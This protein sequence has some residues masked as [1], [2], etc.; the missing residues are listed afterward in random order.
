MAR[1][2]LMAS[3]APPYWVCRAVGCNPD[4]SIF[5]WLLA[6]CA[7]NFSL[8]VLLLRRFVGAAMLPSSIGAYLFCFAAV[9]VG[10]VAHLQLLPHCFVLGSVL[11][12]AAYVMNVL[13][14]G[15]AWAG[16]GWA[17]AAGVLLALQSYGAFYLL[18]FYGLAYVVSIFIGMSL[19][20]G[21]RFFLHA[22]RRDS[23]ALILMALVVVLLARPAYMRYSR[24]AEREGT[25]SVKYAVA[26][27]WKIADL[28]APTSRSWYHVQVLPDRRNVFKNTQTS[29]TLGWV[30]SLVIL[31]GMLLLL[32]RPTPRFFAISF[33]LTAMLGFTV[34]GRS[35]WGAVYHTVPGASAIRATFRVALLLH[36][37]AAIAFALALDWA[38]KKK[39]I[40]RVAAVAVAGWMALEQ[41]PSTYVTHRWSFDQAV[42]RV[43]EAIPPDCESFFLTGAQRN[44]LAQAEV[45]VWAAFNSGVPTVNGRA[46]KMPQGFRELIG[47]RPGHGPAFSTRSRLHNWLASHGR[48]D[49]RVAIIRVNTGTLIRTI[50]PLSKDNRSL[51]PR[52]RRLHTTSKRNPG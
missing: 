43:T 22:A 51:S 6:M 52:K 9:R 36:V 39:G 1:G 14:R 18:L 2:D 19:K 30:T 40:W 28:A 12:A 13:G 15:N 38:L 17:L 25:P 42:R 11:C 7:I 31:A 33:F 27:G 47:R 5:V 26:G 35:L 41:V 50:R 44:R 21:R 16:R 37:P 48:P 10:N 49:D 29:V 20:T 3:F 8:V 4:V 45:A 23:W 32:R 46:G 34:A 24:V